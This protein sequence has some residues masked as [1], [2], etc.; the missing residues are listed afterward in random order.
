MVEV[1]EAA[2]PLTNMRDTLNPGGVIYG[3]SCSVDNTF[4]NRIKR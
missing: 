4:L 2:T 3:F 1:K